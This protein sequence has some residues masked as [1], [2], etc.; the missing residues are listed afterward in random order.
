MVTGDKF[1]GDKVTGDKVYGDKITNIQ[2]APK[3]KPTLVLSHGEYCASLTGFRRYLRPEMLPFVAPEEG[4]NTKPEAILSRL[5]ALAGSGGVLLKGV[6]GVGKTRTALEVGHR[7]EAKGWRVLHALPGEPGVTV[8]EIGGVLLS[9]SAPTLLVFDYLDQMPNL[10]LGSLLGRLLPEAKCRGI[11]LALLAN[12]RPA[13]LRQR[14]GARETLFKKENWLSLEPSAQQKTQINDSVLDRLAPQAVR[15][16]G[17]E[18]VRELC[19][20]RPILALFI[21]E[22]LERRALAG[23]LAWAIRANMRGCDLLGWLRRRMVEDKL[24]VEEGMDFLPPEPS[25]QLIAAAAMLAA[26]PLVREAMVEVGRSASREA[27]GTEDRLAEKTLAG[28][29]QLGWLEDIG[30]ELVAAH[31]VVADEVLAQVSWDQVDDNLREWV[32]PWCLAPARGCARVLGRYATALSR[33]LGAEETK[34]DAALGAGANQWLREEAAGLGQALAAAEASESANA[35]GALV[36]LPIWAGESVA[37]W[38]PLVVPWLASHGLHPAARH[39]LYKGLRTIPTNAAPDLLDAAMTWCPRYLDLSLAS[40][41]L[42]P[43]LG[44]NDLGRHTAKAI[45]LALGWL[46]RFPQ[47]EESVY[48]IQSLL[49][50]AELADCEPE[51]IDFA[52]GWLECFHQAPEAR[53]VLRPLLERKDLGE[54]ATQAVERALGWLECFHQ[55]PEAGFVLQPLLERKDLGEQAPQAVERAL[56]W[57]ESF[58][59]APEARYVLQPLL[60]RTDLGGHKLRLIQIAMIWLSRFRKTYGADLVLEALMGVADSGQQADQIFDFSL[61]WLEIFHQKKSAQ[62]LFMLLLGCADYR[63]HAPKAIAFA[64]AW[65]EQFPLHWRAKDAFEKLLLHPDLGSHAPRLTILALAWL[66]EHKQTKTV[67]PLIDI[68]LRHPQLSDSDW[69]HV[70]KI[71]IT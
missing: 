62:F 37:N 59:Q 40:Y 51:A 71:S 26:A 65:L 23:S 21:A 27:G 1:T 61:A 52:L 64:M 4:A 33:L 28:L 44:R 49:G 39:L 50:R 63:G 38:H 11:R 17:K 43:L 15:L 20:T 55:A 30:L 70:S 9:G 18:R 42:G 48:V 6:G 5:E 22:E 3:T 29:L 56:G 58:H 60:Q 7:A 34:A 24:V 16:L 19:G 8:E 25:P 45:E 13:A 10:D 69:A 12:M 31:D 35:L 47:A 46:E 67:K 54:Q 53:F 66:E 57:L 36:S 68:L 14:N 2:E 32:L 41:V